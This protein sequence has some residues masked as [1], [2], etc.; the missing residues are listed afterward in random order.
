MGG[1]PHTMTVGVL[2]SGLGGLTVAAAI[3]RHFPSSSILYIGD[4]ARVPYGT[5][6]PETIR[7]FAV[8]LVRFLVSNPVDAIV[9]ACN[10]ISAVALDAVRAASPVPV[11]DVIA[12]TVAAV[13]ADDVAVI[14]TRAT[15]RSG[16]YAR[17]LPTRRVREIACPL[18]VPIVEE[19]FAASPLAVAVVREHLAE[20]IAEPPELLILGCTHYPYLRDVIQHV[21]PATRLLDSADATAAALQGILGTSEPGTPVHRIVLTM[22]SPAVARLLPTPFHI[23]DVEILPVEA[24]VGT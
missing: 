6:A 14:G 21:L 19:G 1:V 20:L 24:L 11:V 9:V 5:R 17:A 7:A 3:S 15:V 4:T 22:D 12:P 8:E 23:E 18:F 2:D 10:T 13:D 16:A